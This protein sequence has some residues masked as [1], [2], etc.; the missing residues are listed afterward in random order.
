MTLDIKKIQSI[1]TLTLGFFRFKKFDKNTY[2]ITNDAG[3]YAFLG[4]ND[5]EN[6]LAWKFDTLN[7]YENLLK[8]GFI[9]TE[10]YESKMQ[11]SVAL[12]NHFV[13]MWPTLHM[14]VPT[15]RCNH[16]CVYCHAAVVPMTAENFDMDESTAKRVIDTIMHT[17]SPSL[18][19]EFQWGEALVN[20]SIVQYIVEYSQDIAQ[21]LQKNL[22]LSLVSNLSLMTE[23]KLSWLMDRGVEICTSLDGTEALHN[24]NRAWYDGNSHK[25]VSY[26]IQRINEENSKRWRAKIWALLTLTKENLP[27]TIEII[28]H[29]RQLGLNNIFLRWLNPYGFAAADIENL[30]YN[31][32]DWIIQY[33]KSLD[34]IIELNKKWESFR[35][36]ITSIYLLKIFNQIDPAYMDIRS[37]WGLWIWWVAYMY[38]GKVYASD[39]SRM[40]WRMWDDSFFLTDQLETGEA[41]YTAMIDN[42]V[43]K[44]AIQA[45][46]LDGLPWYDDHVYKPYVWVDII[47]NYKASGNI[48][49]ALK[50]D[51]KMKMQFA[52]LDYIF[53]KLRNP[54]DEKVLMSWI[55]KENI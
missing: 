48:F 18:N 9:K 39:E 11:G 14:I 15:L 53:E 38:D 51:E 6:F 41:T 20:Y 13:G 5:F 23:E 32:D 45:S 2:L 30:A 37:P 34:Y 16:K 35:E 50:K 33:K 24:H 22:S 12:K 3:K 21:K 27:N 29:Y 7:D 49:L 28:D 44:T 17:N 4:V 10:D 25:Q 47:H 1:S 26:W 43:T 31:S 40:L 8:K 36:S 42:P 55:R 52:I 19:I 54:E 46:T